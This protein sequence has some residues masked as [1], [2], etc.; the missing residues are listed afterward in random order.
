MCNFR[1]YNDETKLLQLRAPTSWEK[2]TRTWTF[3]W[4]HVA[5]DTSAWAGNHLSWGRMCYLVIHTS[6]KSMNGVLNFSKGWYLLLYRKPKE[7][8]RNLSLRKRDC[9]KFL[10]GLLKRFEV[11]NRNFKSLHNRERGEVS[12]RLVWW[13]VPDS[14]L[15]TVEAH[16][17]RYFWVYP[18]VS[19]CVF[20]LRTGGFCAKWERTV[21]WDAIASSSW[22]RVC[23]I[24]PLLNG[25]LFFLYAMPKV[26]LV[27]QQHWSLRC[28]LKSLSG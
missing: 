1:S 4:F 14:L 24:C 17:N 21:R 20:D 26:C 15:E 28:R 2:A 13:R 16:C 8:R 9:S 22:G 25:F 5:L 12:L 3:P 11:T 18:E 7:G 23:V 10:V 27:H 19:K 6:S